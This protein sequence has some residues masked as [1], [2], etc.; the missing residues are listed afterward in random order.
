[1]AMD[2][3]DSTERTEAVQVGAGVALLVAGAGPR[4]FFTTNP[5]LEGVVEAEWRARLQAVG[6]D[7]LRVVK[8]PLGHG[9]QVLV[10]S[11]GDRGVL[12]EIALQMRSV[13]H[14]QV[15]IY[16][17]ELPA[18][19][20]LGQIERALEAVAV[21]P[22]REA[23]CFRVTTK[24]NGRHEFTSI[25]VQR[26]AGA[27]L[28]RHYGCAV[29]LEHPDVNVRVDVY[30]SV[31]LVGLQLTERA[32]SK[33]YRRRFQPRA[34]LKA[35]VAYALL[36]WAR[37][38]PDAQGAL[39]DP[40][41]GSG[42]ILI[43][44]AQLY[45]RLELYGCDID[46][47]AVRGTRENAEVEG[48]AGR[49]QLLQADARTLSAVYGAGRFRAIVTNPPYGI[50]FGQ[51]LNFDRFYRRILQEC[52]TVLAAEGM[53]VIA[54]FKRTIFYRALTQQ[55]LFKTLEERVVETGDVFPA[56]YV[57]EKIAADQSAM[58]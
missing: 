23:G 8:K 14:V 9:G 5:G 10:E 46:A 6:I 30:D 15:P 43:E 58:E 13:H 29:D 31:C 11:A 17:F 3:S 7:V 55:G 48:L 57:L 45:P 34:A 53:L 49:L 22:L 1:M 36:Q 27:A 54:V 56:I 38:A 26:V 19:D 44:A 39:L 4:L 16:G 33:R 41:C 2:A 50:K 35:P 24:R 32:L 25:D 18:G 52:W 51:H 28:G 21:E 20:K 37:L 42:T 12:E 47:R 40:F